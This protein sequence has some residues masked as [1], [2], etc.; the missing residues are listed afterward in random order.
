LEHDLPAIAFGTGAEIWYLDGTDWKWTTNAGFSVW[1]GGLAG[2]LAYN[3]AGAQAEASNGYHVLCHIFATNICGDDGLTPK[4]IAIQGQAQYATKALAREGAETEI[5]NLVFGSLPLQEI[6]PVGAVIFK[7]SSAPDYAN[8]V[9]SAIIST[10]AGD[11]YVDWRGSNLKASGGSVADHGALAG[12][13]DDDHI[14]YLLADGTRVLAGAW[15][16]GSQILT[17]VNIDSGSIVVSSLTVGTAVLLGIA[18]G[19]IKIGNASTLADLTTGDYNIAIGDNALQYNETGEYNIAIGRYAMAG[20]NATPFDADNNVAVGSYSL[21]N[22]ENGSD[23]NTCLGFGSGYGITTGSNNI[24]LGWNAGYRQT[25]NSNLLILDNQVRASIAEESTNSIIYGIM[26]AT[27]ATQTL[28]LNA[29][30]NI[31]NVLS[32]G[33]A[34][35]FGTA[36]GNIKLGNASTLADL[37]TGDYNIAIGVNALQHNETGQDN[38]AIGR[39]ALVGTDATPFDADYNVA[40]GSYS[41]YSLQN[42]A[43]FNRLSCNYRK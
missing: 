41:L 11:N 15:D 33:T 7:T 30:V 39:D 28:Y 18:D 35:L 25:T 42:G 17:N 3:N 19:N 10:D 29:V 5:N 13:S 23:K 2:R 6:V 34:V 21:F 4:Y 16:M 32:V 12:L 14:Q 1:L 22:I 27:P 43:D 20:A 31:S 9:K 38:I 36:D 8:A 37:T 26:T 40:I 24:L